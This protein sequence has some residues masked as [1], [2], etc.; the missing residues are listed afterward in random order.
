MKRAIL[1]LP[2]LGVSLLLV[3]DGL[4]TL[5]SSYYPEQSRPFGL[6]P[7][8]WGVTLGVLLALSWVRP[9]SRLVRTMFCV[10]ILPITLVLLGHIWFG[11]QYGWEFAASGL[12]FSLLVFAMLVIACICVA[13]FTA[14]TAQANYSS[15]PTC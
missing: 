6:L 4:Y 9:S 3:V 2:M 8:A 14:R 12:T 1:S 10:A 7:V 11:L 5:L 15:K 13:Q